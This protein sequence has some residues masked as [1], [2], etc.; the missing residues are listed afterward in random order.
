MEYWHNYDIGQSRSHRDLN[1][2]RGDIKP[3]AFL[4]L[5]PGD[6][7]QGGR[8]YLYTEKMSFP[9]LLNKVKMKIPDKLQSRGQ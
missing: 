5:L 1:K 7:V 9:S 8:W 4:F 3:T 2:Y 6:H